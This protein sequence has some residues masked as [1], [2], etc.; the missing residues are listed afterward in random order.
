MHELLTP[1]EMGRADALAIG[2][3]PLSGIELMRNA[4]RAAAR[5]ILD[6]FADAECVSILCGP[7]NNG[8]DG[9]VIARELKRAG[10]PVSVFTLAQAKPGTDAALVAEEYNG[11]VSPM[12][13]FS[14]SAGGLLVDALFGAGLTRSVDGPALEAI[15]KTKEA[16]CRVVAVDLPSGLS[17]DSGAVLGDACPADLTVAF[18]RKKPGHLLYPGRILCGELAVADIG[19]RS[20][21]LADIGPSCFENLPK[22]WIDVLPT[23]SA[24]AHKYSRGAVGVF[25]GGPA[26]TGAARLSAEAA[27]RAG[28]GAVTVYS[29][30]NA[31]LVNANHLTSIMLSKLD[32]ADEL[33]EMLKSSRNKAFVLGPGFGIGEKV[34]EF[35]LAVLS[36]KENPPHLVLDADGLTSLAENPATLFD[37]PGN[38]RQSLVLTP[39]EGEFARLFPDHAADPALS[40]LDRARAAAKQASATVIYKG[41]DTVVASPDGRAAINTN[42]TPWLATA[43]SG[44][45]LAG[46]TAALLAQGMPAFEAACASV[47]MHAESGQLVGRSAIAEDLV[48]RLPCVYRSTDR[49]GSE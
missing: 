2:R 31:L 8:G 3:G 16:G 21:I 34:C 28:A 44:D 4:G 38:D 39:H 25:S 17:G 49:G 1:D 46:I 33:A 36:V 14:P 5:E 30:A 19:I 43:G 10:I 35:A 37:R 27:Q 20:D 41:P 9:Y 32:A 13:A 6:R 12:A 15:R 26:S 22:L 29:P 7:G 24:D 11:D 18:F 48:D 42:G 23:P 45:V 47:W 40:K